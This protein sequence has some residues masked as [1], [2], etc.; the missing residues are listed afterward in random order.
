MNAMTKTPRKNMEFFFV[1]CSLPQ[2]TS[3]EILSLTCFFGFFFNNVTL[4]KTVSR[5]N[6]VDQP[7]VDVQ[8]WP[9]ALLSGV[10]ITWK[11]FLA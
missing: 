10:V 11:E 5:L 6:F 7:P 2:G 1:K 4:S 8:K 3:Y 9:N